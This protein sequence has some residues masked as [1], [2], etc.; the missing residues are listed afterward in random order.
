MSEQKEDLTTT[1]A[2]EPTSG[3]HIDQ[4][5]RRLAQGSVAATVLM[6]LA[7][8]PVLGA[9]AGC[10]ISGWMSA[11]TSGPARPPCAGCTPGY[12]KRHP[13]KWC[14]YKPGKCTDRP[15]KGPCQEWEGGTL[16]L[17]VFAGPSRYRGKTLMQVLWLGGAEDPYRLGAHATAALL[18]AAADI[19]YGYNVREVIRLYNAHYASDPEG[20]KTIFQTL[21]ERGCPL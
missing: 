13:K 14:L 21:N 15:E 5:R 20:L 11:N 1:T 10:T 3:E 12:W 19:H 4:T 9:E 16:Y 8:K 6:S 2:E 17:D 18:N 7:N